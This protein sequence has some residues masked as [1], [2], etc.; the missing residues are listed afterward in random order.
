[1]RDRVGALFAV[2][3]GVVLARLVGA[4]GVHIRGVYLSVRKI[5]SPDADPSERPLLV[6]ADLVAGILP[7]TRFAG[8]A[9]GDGKPGSWT[10]RA[11][12]DREAF[13][14]GEVAGP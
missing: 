4:G 6:K 14:A 8:E 11:R 12:A 7:V 1:M 13:I 3:G 5:Y 9:I 10:L 2:N